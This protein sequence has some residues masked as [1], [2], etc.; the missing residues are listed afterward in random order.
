MDNPNVG[1]LFPLS[2]KLGLKFVS[3]SPGIDHSGFD[4]DE[5]QA[6]LGPK[7]FDAL[8]SKV[9]NVFSCGHRHFKGQLVDPKTKAVTTIDLEAHAIY[10]KDLEAFLQAEASQ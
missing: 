7:R 3:A 10:G 8:M 5:V 9:T 4:Y 1:N 2:A 6:K